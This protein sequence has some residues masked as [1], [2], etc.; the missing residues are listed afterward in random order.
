MRDMVS[1]K[2]INLEENI[3]NREQE[4]AIS[5]EA[6]QNIYNLVYEFS[7]FSNNAELSII[8]TNW[9]HQN[10]GL[11]T[12]SYFQIALFLARQRKLELEDIDSNKIKR[13]FFK[14]KNL[15]EIST[16]YP[17]T[18]KEITA[19]EEGTELHSYFIENLP[20]SKERFLVRISEF[21]ETSISSNYG[22]L[23]ADSRMGE[24]KFE[25]IED[26]SE[27]ST[28]GARNILNLY[29]NSALNSA[30]YVAEVLGLY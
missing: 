19:T 8:E 9:L 4:K 23:I 3:T 12:E 1:I 5:R 29:L 24:F 2:S 27:L 14:L 30:N 10:L 17:V 22:T 11:L 16:Q 25:F 13:F 18:S 7:R 20:V 26:G 6:I 21:G 28:E 15:S